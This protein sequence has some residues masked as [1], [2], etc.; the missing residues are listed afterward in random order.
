MSTRTR[1]QIDREQA[2][3]R[4]GMV[5]AKTGPAAEAGVAILEKG[6]NA[7]DAAV[8]TAFAAGVAEP[9]MNGIGGGG[10]LVAH[11]PK[12]GKTGVVDF[13][14]MSPAGA[15]PDMF[16]L[17]GSG[18]DAGLFGWPSTVD[19]ANVMGQ[20]SVAIPGTVAGLAL[21]LETFGTMT[22]AHVLE[23]AIAL[24]EDGVPV[25]W[26]TTYWIGREAGTFRNRFPATAAIYLDA[27]GNPWVSIE[28]TNLTKYR[29]P[30]LAATLRAVAEGG[31]AAFY[32]GEPAKKIVAHLREHGGV[33]TEEDFAAYRASVDPV[34]TVKFRDHQ[35]HTV[36]K[37]S[38]GTS[39]AEALTML[40]LIDLPALG[41]NSLESLH[42]MAQIFRQCF[43]DRFAYLADPAHVDVPLEL[44]LSPQYAQ[45]CVERMSMDP[46]GS[47][48]PGSRVRLGVSHSMP[49]SVPE[50]VHVKDGSTT[51]LSVIDSEGNAVALTQ[52]LLSGWGSRVVAP[53]TGVLLNNG[54]M[55]FD[56]EPGRPNSIGPRKRPLANMAPVVITKDG[57]TVA[58]IGSS[59]GRKIQNCNAQLAVN[60]ID[61]GMDIQAAIS[62]PRID[63]STL[64]LAVDDRIDPAVIEGLRKLGHPVS[65]RDERLLTADFASPTGVRRG[66]DG[67]LTG[68]A[69]PYYF[70][71]TAAGL[72]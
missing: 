1:W 63:A 70:P 7:V 55:W 19:N 24:A 53:G 44:L 9:W 49:A 36:G 30:D 34:V 69:D 21:A 31:P 57:E 42:M 58:S 56:P 45:E 22:L 14:M 11:L 2:S 12:Q 66:P 47:P 5:A 23:P 4:G 65:V 60:L 52:T 41:H 20:R 35:I 48:K 28:Q 33:H 40:N 72:A 32:E 25:T 26:H 38:G 51:H 61:F 62:A 68:G 43:A 18:H 6:G 8:A 17:A 37:G 54:M 13:P 39:L 3:G 15:T 29:N 10:F 71:A 64:S 50:Y 16:P 27:N 67:T 46:I 59:G